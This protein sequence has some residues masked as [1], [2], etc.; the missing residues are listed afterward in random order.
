MGPGSQ[1]DTAGRGAR[2]Q[3]NLRMDVGC[4]E[5]V[6]RLRGKVPRERFLRAL[7]TR[8]VQNT[9]GDEAFDPRA[10][11]AEVEDAAAVQARRKAVEYVDRHRGSQPRLVFL[12]ELVLGLAAEEERSVSDPAGGAKVAM[13][14]K[15]TGRLERL[16][17][18]RVPRDR[19]A[20]AIIE[21]H[22][23]FFA[24]DAQFDCLEFVEEVEAGD[25]L[26]RGV[27]AGI[28]QRRRA[29]GSRLSFVLEHAG[30]L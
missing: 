2:R 29:G 17:A 3:I 22:L 12:Y 30:L 4:I 6:D 26:L 16:S 27:V 8:Q 13:S 7:V 18:G 15:L 14:R 10:S 21:R 5:D 1:G 11:V 9:G 24:D 28:D 23:D 19:Y 20:R 25:S